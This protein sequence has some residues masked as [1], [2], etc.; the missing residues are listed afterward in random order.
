MVCS[1]RANVVKCNEALDIEDV[2]MM[3][4]DDRETTGGPCNPGTAGISTT[5]TGM[6]SN[7][8]VE[9]QQ[10]DAGVSLSADQHG[11]LVTAQS[12]MEETLMVDGQL[13]LMLN[14]NREKKLKNDKDE[15]ERKTRYRS[16][17]RGRKGL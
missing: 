17:T 16:L 3:K 5:D 4:A 10:M 15:T 14:T 13:P 9:Q 12:N 8:K 11:G 7:A 2:Q 1:G 6:S